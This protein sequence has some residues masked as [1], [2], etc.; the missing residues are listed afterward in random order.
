LQE[1]HRQN[2]GTK[3]ASEEVWLFTGSP[4]DLL[5]VARAEERATLGKGEAL[6]LDLKRLVAKALYSVLDAG[7][8]V[9]LPD[10]RNGS[11]E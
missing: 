1:E 6:G 4:A 5:I 8:V 7:E 11:I 10:R 3:P 9:V 2:R